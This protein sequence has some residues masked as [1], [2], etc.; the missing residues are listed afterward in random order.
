MSIRN[1][2]VT[3]FLTA[4]AAMSALA[5]TSTTTTTRNHIFPPVGL[6]SGETL[7][8]NL[9]NIATAS[10]GGTAPSCTGSVSFAGVSTG[11]TVGTPKSTPFTVGAGQIVSVPLTYGASGLTGTHGEI[12]VTL[13]QTFTSPSTAPCALVYS[14]ETFS[15]S[16]GETHLYLTS[17][18]ASSGPGFGR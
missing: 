4:F 18:A 9:V 1:F 10:T 8:V 5:Q 11:T 2:V 6:G 7:Q 12:L 13:S 15:A 3:S 17:A 14:L 16:T